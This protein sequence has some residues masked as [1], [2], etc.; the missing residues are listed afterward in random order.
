MTD[1][2]EA[3]REIIERNVC[4]FTDEYNEGREGV[5]AA[6]VAILPDAEALAGA[7]QEIADNQFRA[8]LTKN[9]LDNYASAAVANYRKGN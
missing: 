8:N 1:R 2:R 7:L 4:S 9:E 5:V 6:I 3:I